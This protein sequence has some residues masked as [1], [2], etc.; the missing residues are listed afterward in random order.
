MHPHLDKFRLL[1]PDYKRA[2]LQ[3]LF[4]ILAS[5]IQSKTVNFYDLKDEVGKIS[6]NYKS[7]AESHYRR[8]TRFFLKHASTSLW[9]S[10][11]KYGLSLLGKD[12]SL[13]YLDG[14]E[15]S[16]GQFKLHCLFLAVDYQGV[17]IPIYFR[18]YNHKGVLSEKERINFIESAQEFC[19]LKNCTIVADR[20][21]I[22][23]TWFVRFYDLSLHFVIRLRKGQYKNNTRKSYETLE[24]KA[25]RRGKATSIVIIEGLKFRLWVVRNANKSE[26]EPLIY[27]LTN[28]IEKRAAP[29][30]YRLRW[31]IESLFKHL[32]TNGYNLEDL[33]MKN[34]NKI[35]LLISIVILAYI[36]AV[37][38]AFKERKKQVVRKKKYKNEIYFD[39]ISIFKQGQ[40]LLKQSFTT[41][42][43]FLEIVQNL[44]IRILTL[45]LNVQ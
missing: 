38:S 23:D 22:G 14:T 41:L 42:R 44:K 6:E 15:W 21:F 20:E 25:L 40:S 17:A 12:A 16:I 4:I 30:L 39:W 35:R 19:G 24:R 33:R 28:L 8:I 45:K 10:V 3:N 29:D 2:C 1:Y 11:L 37:L 26:Q 18:L 31:K 36:L 5:L 43:Q 27:I 34:L 9:S 13:S 32:K 7:K